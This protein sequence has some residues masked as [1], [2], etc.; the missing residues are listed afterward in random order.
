M[1]GSISMGIGYFCFYKGMN[2]AGVWSIIA[3]DEI[4]YEGG[5]ES[6]SMPLLC[7]FG[8]LTGIGGTTTFLGALK[9]GK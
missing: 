4:A 5:P 3:E 7:L 2:T 1:L 6:V 8:A 9:T